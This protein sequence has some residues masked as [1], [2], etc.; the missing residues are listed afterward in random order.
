MMNLIAKNI[1][2]IIMVCLIIIGVTA[3]SACDSNDIVVESTTVTITFES[4]VEG[5]TIRP[6]SGFVG[7]NITAPTEPTR[8]GFEFLGW[9][10]ENG[11]LFRLTRFP[12][13]SITLF[14]KWGDDNKELITFKI[15]FLTNSDEYI[16]P[17]WFSE[18]DEIST[19]PIPEFFEANGLVSVFDDWYYNDE[20]FDF[21][22]MPKQDIVLQGQWMTGDYAVYFDT[23]TDAELQPIVMEPGEDITAPNRLLL[24]D[25]AIFKGWTYQ[26]KPYIFDEM[27]SESI[28]LEADWFSTEDSVYNEALNIPKLFINLEENEQLTSITKEEYVHSS[29]T[30]T[31]TDEDDELYAVSAK[32]RGRGN[33]SWFAS[34][35]KRGYKIKFYDKQELF[36]EEESKTWVILA[37]SNFYDPTMLKTKLAFDMAD[38]IFDKLEY[39]SSTNWIELYVN[40]EYRGIYILAEHMRVSS[41][42]ID[43]DSEYGVDDTG[44]LIEYDSYANEGI[45]GLNYFM[46][47]GYRYGFTIKSPD[48]DDFLDEGLSEERYRQ[49]VDFIRD[50]TSETLIAALNSPNNAQAYE[51]FTNNA[52]VASFVDMYIL[53]ELFKNTDTG[54]SSFYMYKEAGGKLYAGHPWDF[55][56]TAGSNRGDPSP[57]GLYVAGSAAY[58]SDFTSSELYLAL[59]QVDAFKNEVKLR[60]QEITTD[61]ELFVNQN[62][63]DAFIEENKEALGKNY[64]FWSENANIEGLIVTGRFEYI[65]YTS[66][67]NAETGWVN[68]TNTLK[69]WLL[70]R[71]EWLNDEWS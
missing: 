58:E 15:E 62:M 21:T 37:A 66:L 39:V 67:E 34:G 3:L 71:I 19:L 18:G 6:I 63:S 9:E 17:I 50:Y 55:D 40:G 26:D 12:E 64:Y 52:D 33:G 53:H 22:I 45:L 2:R 60:W 5:M 27:P 38:Q 16:M 25:N 24:K 31:N 36:G 51:T 35:P 46:V 30:L 28:I 44:Y 61:I 68:S 20:V 65:Q 4:G 1:R 13:E 56:A 54:W 8:D 47:N 48:A 29:I 43:I 11:N 42:R 23:N 32:I 49:Q 70:D 41:D 14:A 10:D 59:M 57:T 7:K 69:R